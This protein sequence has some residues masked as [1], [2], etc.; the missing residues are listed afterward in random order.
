MKD[1]NKT[2]A[3]LVEELTE[4]RRELGGTLITGVKQ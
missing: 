3:P 2:K 4:L 1:E